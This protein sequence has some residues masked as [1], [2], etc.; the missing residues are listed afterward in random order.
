M[1]RLRRDVFWAEVLH[2]PTMNQL[3]T[4]CRKCCCREPSYSSISIDPKGLMI[5]RWIY[6]AGSVQFW[7]LER[8]RMRSNPAGL[9]DWISVAAALC[10]VLRVNNDYVSQCDM[11]V[12]QT[13]TGLQ[14][15]NLVDSAHSCICITS[16]IAM[17]QRSDEKL[18]TRSLLVHMMFLHQC[19]KVLKE[20][21]CTPASIIFVSSSCLCPQYTEPWGQVES[22]ASPCRWRS[23]A[24]RSSDRR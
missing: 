19:R 1:T 22:V 20:R 14:L 4:A 15:R 18:D 23:W 6:S 5:K 16:K 8:R 17:I 13:T 7:V 24:C 11:I 3:F 9:E 12:S 21:I 10:S 2:P